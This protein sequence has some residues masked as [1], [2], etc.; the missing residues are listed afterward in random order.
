MSLFPKSAFADQVTLDGDFRIGFDK[1]INSYIRVGPNIAIGGDEAY[2]YP[3]YQINSVEKNSID[4]QAGKKIYENGNFTAD[5]EV[6]YPIT[7]QNAGI[8]NIKIQGD[9]ILK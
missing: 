9:W 4:L 6:N 1:E 8:T 7:G 2:I 3:S 5:I